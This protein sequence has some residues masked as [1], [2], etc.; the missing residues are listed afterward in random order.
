MAH[1]DMPELAMLGDVVEV[2]EH[3][4]GATLITGLILYKPNG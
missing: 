1:G 4:A 2:A 3:D